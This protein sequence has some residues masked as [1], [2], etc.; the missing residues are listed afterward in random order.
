MKSPTC[1]PRVSFARDPCLF[2]ASVADGCLCHP[3]GVTSGATALYKPGGCMAG[4][5]N[6]GISSL[7]VAVLFSLTGYAHDGYLTETFFLFKMNSNTQ[8]LQWD[9]DLGQVTSRK[10][11]SDQLLPFTLNLSRQVQKPEPAQ[12]GAAIV[13]LA[14]SL[15]PGP[16]WYSFPTAS[17]AT[18]PLP[19]GTQPQS[20]PP[21]PKRT[22]DLRAGLVGG[23][24]IGVGV[25]LMATSEKKLGHDP[26]CFLC[27]P[28]TS[29]EQ[30]G[31]F[32]YY[33]R[34][35]VGGVLSAGM[36]ALLLVLA[37]F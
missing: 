8:L 13:P 29:E 12:L 31:C 2:I 9:S 26:F 22:F 19:Q 21:L 1:R 20:S 30:P 4:K 32:S 11:P 27:R 35:M 3:P 18:F 17:M 16:S 28:C 7:L 33:D 24:L 25:Y 10:S 15:S 6:K 34:K 23:A 14:T 37:S 5:T 36:G